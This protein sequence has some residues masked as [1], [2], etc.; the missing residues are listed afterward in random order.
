MGQCGLSLSFTEGPQTSP[1]NLNCA[2]DCNGTILVIPTPNGQGPFTYAW[3]TVPAQMAQAA[4]GLCAGI[5]T[6]TITDGS[7]CDT[8]AV[9]SI[10]A[11]PPVT[12]VFTETPACNGQCNG[13]AMLNVGGGCSGLG[14]CPYDYV[15]T[16]LTTSTTLV[17]SVDSII[18][19]TGLCPGDYSISVTDQI[20]CPATITNITIT[21][22]SAL[23][24]IISGTDITCPGLCDG[25]STVNVTGSQQP[26]T[27]NWSD[28]QS[29]SNQSSGTILSGLCAGLYDVTITDSLGCTATE[30][31]NIT[32]PLPISFAANTVDPTCN[33]IC[34]GS[35]TI[36][37][38]TGGTGPYSYQW[39]TIPAQTDM[40]ATGLCGQVSYS[41]TIS[42]SRSCTVIDTFMLSQ[43]TVLETNASV[44]CSDA[45]NMSAT[46]TVEVLNGI[47]PYT[48]SWSTGAVSLSITD[49]SIGE[50]Y[51]VTITDGNGCDVQETVFIEPD[52]CPF[53]IIIPNTFSPNE[54]GFN[55]IWEIE[56][57]SIYS[58]AKVKVYNRWGDIVFTSTGYDTP[59]EGKSGTPL[60]AAVYYYVITVESISETYAGSVTIVK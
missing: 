39:S 33:A 18:S 27:F 9:D 34:D 41:V 20:P 38:P 16:N 15:W 2:S 59:W 54:D 37:S 45:G 25:T 46:A 4:T 35:V 58:D 14:L 49:A 21:E 31:I 3:N 47:A 57:L 32:E 28:G 36:S 30:S 43:A 11:P 1:P 7:G 48:Y 29:S 50:T 10:V 12:A 23:M 60:P 40:I 6:V 52:I 13:V 17:G 5:Y 24:P 42:D 26:Y 53:E 19:F 8:V 22:A 44:I 55:D 51:N 56:N